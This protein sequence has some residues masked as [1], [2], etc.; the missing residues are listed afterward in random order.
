MCIYTITGAR[1]VDISDEAYE[2]LFCLKG[3]P[4]MSIPEVTLKYT[5][6]QKELSEI[7]RGSGFNEERA[8]MAEKPS[9]E[10]RLGA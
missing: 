2:R 8:D 1:I 9:G 10:I 6:P 3:I 5:S 4:D 7:L